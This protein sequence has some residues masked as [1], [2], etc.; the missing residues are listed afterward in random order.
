MLKNASG[1]R[2]PP[3]NSPQM[4]KNASG[5]RVKASLQ[6]CFFIWGEVGGGSFSPNVF[7]HLGTTVAQPYRGEVW[8]GVRSRRFPHA[9]DRGGDFLLVN[10]NQLAVSLD[11]GALAFDARYDL[12][13]NVQRG[14]GNF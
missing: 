2:V 9:V 11:D 1:R 4:L 10:F 3:S 7:F 5:G 12:A 6:M 8:R 14:E 13:L